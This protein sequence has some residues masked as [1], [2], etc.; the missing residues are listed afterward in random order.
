MMYIV[1]LMPVWLNIRIKDL[2]PYPDKKF[3]DTLEKEVG[4]SKN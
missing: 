3:I 4:K 2:T 1:T